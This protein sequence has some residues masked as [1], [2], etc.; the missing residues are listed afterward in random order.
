M[1]WLA[2]LLLAASSQAADDGFK[3]LFNGR[4]LDGWVVDTKEL[5]TVRD[6]M[7]VGKHDGF[8]YNDFLRTARN[9]KDFEL[10]LKFRLMNGEGNS[11]V[12][13][14]SKPVPDSHEVAGYQADIGAQYWGCLYDESRRK[15]VLAQAPQDTLSGLDKTGWNEYVIRAQGNHITMHLNGK[16]T[17]DYTEPEPGMDI[18]GFIALQVHS[19]PKIE[20]WFKDI[21][22]RELK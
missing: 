3:P 21:Q 16:K 11:G 5:W 8:K 6:G 18:P 10:K 2:V 19:G 17:V 22:L 7:V 20:V 9:Y 15:K 14:R 13:F 12:Q 1:R 4:N